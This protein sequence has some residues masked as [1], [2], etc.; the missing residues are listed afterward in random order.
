M[1]F[2]LT[3][4]TL[5]F[6]HC[7]GYLLC[8]SNPSNNTCSINSTKTFL[9]EPAPECK[10]EM[11]CVVLDPKLP[12]T[13]H[14]CYIFN[15]GCELPACGWFNLKHNTFSRLLLFQSSLNCLFFYVEEHNQC[16]PKPDNPD[17]DCLTPLQYTKCCEFNKICSGVLCASF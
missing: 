8:N 15:I 3:L 9:I 11:T 10:E 17:G 1:H 13:A 12:T 6:A 5:L 16:T 7:L 4:Y 14:C 2:Y